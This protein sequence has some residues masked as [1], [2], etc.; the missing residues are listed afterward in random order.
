MYRGTRVIARR[1]ASPPLAGRQR[2]LLFKDAFA[3]R[4]LGFFFHSEVS[5]SRTGGGAASATATQPTASGAAAAARSAADPAGLPAAGASSLNTMKDAHEVP[6]SN[7]SE[8]RS[9]IDGAT[10]RSNSS[11]TT[12]SERSHGSSNSVTTKDEGS[13]IKDSSDGTE[14]S[15]NKSRI[16]E[17]NTADEDA[18]W[19]KVQWTWPRGIAALSVASFAGW[20]GYEF[21][22]SGESGLRPS[23]FVC[24]APPGRS[25][26]SPSSLEMHV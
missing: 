3:C 20:F 12:A 18:H 4:S 8:A 24:N 25:F 15:T 6:A 17:K 2:F 9:G 19:W 5:Q 21:V 16:E 1:A 14:S 7:A 10:D 11:S 13:A 22:E 23:S 26:A